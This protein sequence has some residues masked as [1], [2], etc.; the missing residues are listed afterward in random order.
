MRVSCKTWA[1]TNQARTM[2]PNLAL[3]GGRPRAASL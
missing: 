2:L 1:L 3:Q